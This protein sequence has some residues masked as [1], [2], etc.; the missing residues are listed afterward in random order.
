MKKYFFP[1]L[2]LLIVLAAAA[3]TA[4]NS[5]Y[6]P[7]AR[8][9]STAPLCLSLSTNLGLGSKGEEVTRLQDFLRSIGYFTSAST[10]YYGPMT[11]A[12]VKNFQNAAGL[13]PVGSV[14]PL[15]RSVIQKVTCEQATQP[16]QP[17]QTVPPPVAPIVIVTA[18]TSTAASTTTAAASSSLPYTAQTFDDWK[19]AWGNVS[20]SSSGALRLRGS[21]DNNGA[22]AIYPKSMDWT[23]YR[24][25]ADTSVANGNISLIARYVDSNNFISCSFAKNWVEIDQVHNGSSSVLIAKSVEG[26]LP[27]TD[28]LTKTTSV[29]MD[30][31][32]GTVGCTG[33]GPADN[34][35]YT[36]PTGSPLKGGIGIESWYGTPLADRLDLLSVK[37]D[38]L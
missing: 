4:F 33:Y 9:Q 16:A 11:A 18:A 1:A 20:T 10:G 15:T 14:G 3:N 12:A 5:G 2:L 6:V 26:I 31:K 30:V 23:D 22:E 35:T 8:A 32:G 24:Y 34:L 17:A 13:P 27:G 37:V 36:L 38:S 25:Q 7:L 28:G 19:A 21:L 29:A